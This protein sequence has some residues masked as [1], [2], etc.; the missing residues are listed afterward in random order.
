MFIFIL[1]IEVRKDTVNLIRRVTIFKLLYEITHSSHCPPN[2][3]HN[4][5]LDTRDA[6]EP[7]QMLWLM[8]SGIR[9][10]VY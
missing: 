2:I 6:G 10:L 8:I 3:P 4:T 9:S 7:K 1:G 5:G